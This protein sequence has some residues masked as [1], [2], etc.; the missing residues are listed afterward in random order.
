MSFTVFFIFIFFIIFL[1]SLLLLILILI[2]IPLIQTLL[3]RDLA[4]EAF[5]FIINT[6]MKVHSYVF[7]TMRLAVSHTTSSSQ[8]AGSNTQHIFFTNAIFKDVIFI[9]VAGS[10]TQHIFFTMFP[11]L[12]TY[13]CS[14][15]IL[16]LFFLLFWVGFVAL[17]VL[18][19]VFQLTR[20]IL[21]LV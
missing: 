16:V 21:D 2:L 15:W 14:R 13:F 17:L 10:N 3:A 8:W 12:S 5:L 1:H 11:S 20:P 4:P 18:F 19:G 6:F 9:I 7:F